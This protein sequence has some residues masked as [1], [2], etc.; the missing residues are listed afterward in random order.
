MQKQLE[1]MIDL[2]VAFNPEDKI[3]RIGFTEEHIT[4]TGIIKK[5]SADGASKEDVNSIVKKKQEQY[6]EFTITLVDELVR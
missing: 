2:A 5:L 4:V 3:V 6:P 1:T